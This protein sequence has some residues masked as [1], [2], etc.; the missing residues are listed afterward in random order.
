MINRIFANNRSVFVISF[1]LAVLIW[2]VAFQ[3]EG[4]SGASG[5]FG[6]RSQ[7]F[8]N[9]PI[10]VLNVPVDENDNPLYYS[11]SQTAVAN[12]TLTGNS[13]VISQT[14]NNDITASID[15][16]GLTEGSYNL[17]VKIEPRSSALYVSS[18]QVMVTVHLEPYISKDL[19]ISIAYIGDLAG[20]L[21]LQQ[22]SLSPQIVTIIGPRS[23][24]DTVDAARAV[25]DQSEVVGDIELDLP[26]QF[27]DSAGQIIDGAELEVL[28]AAV[29]HL[30]QAVR[31]SR[32]LAI[33]FATVNLPEELRLLSRS[34]DP[35]TCVVY[36]S[37]EALMDVTV[38][39]TQ[40][41]D[42]LAMTDEE[43]RDIGLSEQDLLWTILQ[44]EEQL[45]I[46]QG[47]QFRQ[48]L[49][50]SLDLPSGFSF[51]DVENRVSDSVRLY[52]ELEWIGE[53]RIVSEVYGE[54]Y[55]SVAGNLDEPS[56][57]SAVQSVYGD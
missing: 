47:E 37:P 36:A 33:A 16:S 15:L 12:L 30:S 17:E 44:D 40:P 55:R 57:E 41:L 31:I 5:T 28:P 42:L 54:V 29:V 13:L 56:D 48:E 49:E 3:E 2:L 39:S 7:G 21:T 8:S 34:Y 4:Q 52:L 23:L 53:T 1:M 38:L 20:N 32:E 35:S 50:L 11:L 10:Q 25:V 26:V 9:I 19:E 22:P 27:Y 14:T 51:S 18:Q 6:E 24:V 45:S 46:E 43:L